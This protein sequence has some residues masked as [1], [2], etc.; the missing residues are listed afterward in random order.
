MHA[1]HKLTPGAGNTHKYMLKH[2]LSRARTRAHT[3][4]HTH[5][6]TGAIVG[7]AALG[8]NSIRLLLLP[9]MG[10]YVRR[11]A[12]LLEPT[13]TPSTARAAAGGDSASRA[14]GG[15]SAAMGVAAEAQR[16]L[17]ALVE[18]AAGA[19][20]ERVVGKAE[21]E[22]PDTL[23]AASR[24]RLR[25]LPK[26]VAA[27]R[28]SAAAAAAAGATPAAGGQQQPTQPAQQQQGG[29]AMEVDACGGVKEEGGALQGEPR[30]P[31]GR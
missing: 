31:G 7:L 19:M 28:P 10:P 4:T 5:T 3:H 21:K 26:A 20:Y 18:A 24:P 6:H 12:P 13:S 14:E 23:L 11:L 22:L 9:Q 8:P 15:G 16:V 17:G 25:V 1:A 2:T 27:T 30:G 29:E